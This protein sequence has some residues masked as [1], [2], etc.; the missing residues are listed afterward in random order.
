MDEITARTLNQG[1]HLVSSST[2]RADY[3]QVA[4]TI[5][6]SFPQISMAAW[7][8]LLVTAQ[9]VLAASTISGPFGGKAAPLDGEFILKVACEIDEDGLLDEDVSDQIRDLHP[10]EIA[11][12]YLVT[13]RYWGEDR[14]AEV[15]LAS[16]LATIAGRK[17]EDVFFC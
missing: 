7:Q 12:I 9:D 13:D 11:A 5:K 6:A 15:T 17:E 8:V 16:F 10:D 1:G 3:T 2:V 4:N 14:P